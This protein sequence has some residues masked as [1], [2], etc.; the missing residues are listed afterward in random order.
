MTPDVDIDFWIVVASMVVLSAP[1]IS[2]ILSALVPLRYSWLVSLTASFMLLLAV[3]GAVVLAS[4]AGLE[5]PQHFSMPWFG[6]GGN[7]VSVG[8]FIDKYTVVMVLVV[9][10]VSFFVHMYSAGY[11][12]GDAAIRRYFVM[13]GFFTFTMLGIVLSD[14][15]LVVFM[16]WELVGFSSYMLIGHWMELP[17]AAKASRKAYM[18]NRIGDLGFVAGLMIVYRNAGTFD[19][20]VLATQGLQGWEIAAALC[21][22]VAIAAKSAQFPLFTWL[23]DAMAGPTPVSALIH[24]AT[25]VAAGVF[26]L[27]RIHF[28]FPPLALQ[29][30]TIA[31]LATALTGAAAALG[32]FDIK[33]ILAY[34]TVSQ[35]GL[36]VAAL[37]A[38]AKDAAM[39]HLLTHAF[40][41][42]GL[43]LAAGAI[44]HTLHQAQM[45]TG[46]TYDVQDI[47]NLGGLRKAMP[48]TFGVFLICGASLSGIPMFSGFQSKEAILSSI[49]AGGDAVGMAVAALFLIATFLTVTYTF[50]LI[51]FAFIAERSGSASEVSWRNVPEVP[52][53]MRFPMIV[54]ALASLWWIVSL[55]PFSFSGWFTTGTASALTTVVSVGVVL[56]ALAF[57][58]LFFRNRSEP[59]RVADVLTNTFYLDAL[60]A[61]VV[62]R[63]VG[64]LSALCARVD[65]KYI[66]GFLHG[67]A[68]I[69]VT[70]AHI[71][72]WFDKAVVDG[73]VN[74]VARLTSWLGAF[75]RTF[76]SGNIHKYIF[77]AGMGLVLL[78]LYIVA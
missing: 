5:K 76:Q 3:A 78:T 61:I 56:G 21:I 43:F 23:P 72:G 20:T 77:W 62:T 71:V 35:L 70:L 44:I 48:V 59:S 42:A 54:L 1:L 58:Y 68:Y 74:L 65:R 22:F 53:V 45:S 57:A 39:L 6:L 28:L 31:G 55:N 67:S 10:I 30:V 33:K 27:A 26:L 15:L 12:A 51:W 50:R 2:G 8:I 64:H 52:F 25:M 75:V 37:G 60:Y 46:E 24:A 19:I 18:M 38:G 73:F 49:L 9:T 16:C 66:D 40:F 63:P 47:R 32:H 4:T 11:M 13:L 29:V 14:N 17:E 34:S 7:T 41:K 69:Q 36:M